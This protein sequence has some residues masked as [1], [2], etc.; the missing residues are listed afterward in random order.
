MPRVLAIDGRPANEA[1]RAGIGNF[2]AGLLGELPR[3][4]ADAGW[5]LRVYLSTPPRPGF[6]VSAGQAEFRVLPVSPFWTHRRLGPALRREPPDVF[7]APGVQVPLFARC[8]SVATLYDLAVMRYPGEFTRR[9]RWLARLELRHARGA[10]A[11]FV[12]IS[13]TTLE[14]AVNLLGVPRE[15][16]TI[17]TPGCDTRFEPCPEPEQERQLRARMGLEGPYVLYVGRIQPR[18]NLV[19]LMQA[20][21]R[22]CARHPDWPHRL[23]I[24]GAS[25]WMDDPIRAAADKLA[26]AERI[27]FTG[28]VPDADLPLLM[29]GAELFALVS[30]WEGFGMPLIEAMAC[31]TPA[32][33]S[34]TSALDE[35]AGDAALRVDPLDTDAIASSMEQL[36]TNAPLRACLVQQGLAQAARYTWAETARG[37]IS[38]ADAAA[39]K[40]I[41][42]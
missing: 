8:P 33:T 14:D 42:P 17:A 22:V 28:F 11:R 29:A 20:F 30:L 39:T 41:M 3:A 21:D 13:K 27:T 7:Y 16:L 35:V 15:R 31:G 19:R 38:A 37:V 9:R 25:G 5:R 36:L 4:A 32:L 1:Q 10:C 18:K 24:A 2:C 34:N 6:P 12:A 40:G 23:V 26:H